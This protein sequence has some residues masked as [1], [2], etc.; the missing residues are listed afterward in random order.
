[1]PKK[2]KGKKGKKSGDATEGSDT[3]S[4]DAY[5]SLVAA[6]LQFGV[7]L[8]KLLRSP[9]ASKEVLQSRRCC[10][11]KGNAC[12]LS[13]RCCSQGFGAVLSYKETLFPFLALPSQ[14]SL[15]KRVFDE[16]AQS[17]ATSAERLA[18]IVN[19]KLTLIESIK[20]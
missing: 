18:S 4:I 19:D 7:C 20:F 11:C 12:S 10:L 8:R 1:M 13:S 16:C 6:T 14:D 2:K 17:Q 9:S 5:K 15:R 3:G